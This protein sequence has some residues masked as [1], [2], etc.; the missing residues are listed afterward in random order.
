MNVQTPSRPRKSEIT[1]A[2]LI[3]A[4]H[5]VF[6]R[7]HYQNARITDICA[8][9]GKANGVFYRY[10]TNKEDI[11]SACFEQF[12]ADLRES[13]PPAEAFDEDLP[14]AIRAA[15]RVYWDKYVSY[16]GVVTGLFEAGI[17]DP[18]IA[19]MWRR[20]RHRGVRQFAHRIA[21]QQEAGRCAHLD[22]EIAASAL[23]CMFEFSC[24]NWMS[25]RI[26]LVRENVDPEVAIENLYQM[27][28]RIL[29]I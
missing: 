11:F 4:A 19:R 1:R 18:E 6:A 3:D 26:D 23:M 27:I 14:T 15:T 10:F 5:R 22:P 29:E 24:Y 8:E 2:Q 7:E 25:Q 20:V 13:S 28:A 9:A 12:L 17:S 16:Y 21:L